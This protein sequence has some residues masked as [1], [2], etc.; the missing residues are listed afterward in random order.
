MTELDRLEK[1]K[2]IFHRINEMSEIKRQYLEALLDSMIADDSG[3][4]E[5]NI[6]RHLAGERVT[7][8]YVNVETGKSVHVPMGE[9]RPEHCMP[10]PGDVS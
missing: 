5:D 6:Q 4:V 7:T 1:V 9:P 2:E 10:L 3:S 8:D